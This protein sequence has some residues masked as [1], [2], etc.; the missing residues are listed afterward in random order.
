MTKADKIKSA[1][2]AVT[3]KWTK[4]RKAE[5]KNASA[6]HR[7]RDAMMRSRKIT[8]KDAAGAVMKQAYMKP[9]AE[10]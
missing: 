6:R 8:I 1:L 9:C 7:R 4:Q 10:R 3:G 5:E 2:E